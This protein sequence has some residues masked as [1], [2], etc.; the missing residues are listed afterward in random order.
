VIRAP[1]IAATGN[2]MRPFIAFIRKQPEAGFLVSFPDLPHCDS[3][4]RT[5]IEARDNAEGAL[6]RHCRRL[7]E[8]G[9][10]VPPPSYLHDLAWS[11]ARITDGLIALIRPSTGAA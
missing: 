6:T 8:T 10:A 3:T 9:T 7:H 1:I 4:G 5:I 11:P 2:V